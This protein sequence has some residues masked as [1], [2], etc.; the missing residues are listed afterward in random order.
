MGGFLSLDH[1]SG[2]TS[3]T[4]R[5]LSDGPDCRSYSSYSCALAQ[6]HRIKSGPFHDFDKN[7][8]T[9]FECF[10][11]T[12]TSMSPVHR[13]PPLKP[14][15]YSCRCQT[16]TSLV[17]RRRHRMALRPLPIVVRGSHL[18]VPDIT[19]HTILN[20]TTDSLA[21]VSQDTSNSRVSSPQDDDL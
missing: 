18:P 14:K 20:A 19:T 12:V 2:Q 21:T 17:S 9:S 8:E 3:G 4:T 13:T 10:T 7:F 16:E 15:S 11:P 6:F 5:A 1:C